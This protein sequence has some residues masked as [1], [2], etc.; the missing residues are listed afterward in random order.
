M[1]TEEERP[2]GEATRL[3]A[4]SDELGSALIHGLDLPIAALRAAIESMRDMLLR[5]EGG[6]RLLKGVLEEVDRLGK[7]VR[8]LVDYA[9]PR[10][11]A[12]LR[13][14]ALEI[15]VS[16]QEGLPL[17]SRA[18]VLIAL[19]GTDKT[20]RTDAPLLVRDLRH[21]L[22]NAL[23]A[24]SHDVLVVVHRGAGRTRFTVV[25]GS[26][27]DFDEDWARSAF[28]STKQNHLGLG[29]AIAARDVALMNGTLEI[30]NTPN[31]ETIATITVPD[32]AD[33]REA[34]A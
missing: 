11:P 24:S 33:A 34:A 29:L 10:D 17:H 2:Q 6:H 1:R 22:E 25:D 20:I 12:P 5:D 9:T 23:E 14:T 4:S 18:R 21:L 7:N 3:F 19:D 8:D 13:C 26:G 28:H 16:A 31:G 30:Q 32:C 15:A 27:R